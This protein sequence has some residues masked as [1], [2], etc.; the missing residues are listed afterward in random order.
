M[1]DFK[2]EQN[3]TSLTAKNANVKR[4]E[5]IKQIESLQ[6]FYYDIGYDTANI[7]TIF[8]LTLSYLRGQ[9]NK[10]V[11]KSF[12]DVLMAQDKLSLNKEINL[13]NCFD[14]LIDELEFSDSSKSSFP[15]TRKATTKTVNKQLNLGVQDAA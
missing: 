9:V 8:S 14:D 7:K 2:V 15:F 12:F 1:S 5:L 10:L 6:R 4:S 13:L 3:T 11:V